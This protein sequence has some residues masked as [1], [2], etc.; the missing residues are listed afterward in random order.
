MNVSTQNFIEETIILQRLLPESL[1]G[2]LLL[3]LLL[4]EASLEALKAA[5]G[6]RHHCLRICHRLQG[7]GVGR[8][9]GLNGRVVELGH[10][11]RARGVLAEDAQVFAASDH[12]NHRLR[13]LTISGQAIVQLTSGRQ[14]KVRAMG[15]RQKAAG[16]GAV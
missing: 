7:G 5:T 6:L 15:A 14:R 1:L 10:V 11:Q 16:G 12:R 3:L 8:G 13:K 9:G 4:Q 2:P